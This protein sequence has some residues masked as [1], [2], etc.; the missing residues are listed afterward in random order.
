MSE[1]YI[2]IKGEDAMKY[3]KCMLMIIVLS[4]QSIIFGM[5]IGEF[6]PVNT[7]KVQE[8]M[9]TY[10]KRDIAKFKEVFPKMD[11]ASQRNVLKNILVYPLGD[12]SK[13]ETYND[14]F[15][16]LLPLFSDEDIQYLLSRAEQLKYE[17]KKRILGEYLAQ[18]ERSEWS[19]I[20]S[21]RLQ[22]MMIHRGTP[23]LEEFKALN[24]K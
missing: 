12:R 17:G 22:H 6:N 4:G 20:Q 3:A 9:G 1:N 8:A 16:E 11:A 21:E 15:K 24:R 2:K 10:T 13:N 18:K 5:E 14:I 7:Q 23:S 19:T